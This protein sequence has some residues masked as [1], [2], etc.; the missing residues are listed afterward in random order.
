LSELRDLAGTSK[1][2][3]IDV[4]CPSEEGIF[5]LWVWVQLLR[6]YGSGPIAPAVVDA[7]ALAAELGAQASSSPSEAEQ[8]RFVAF[9]RVVE[10]L[11]RA[12]SHQPLVIAI[13]DLQHADTASLLLLK[14]LAGSISKEPIAL[15]ATYR[16]VIAKTQPVLSRTLGALTREDPT[17]QM[18]LDPLSRADIAALA[19]S[20][21]DR[22]PDDTLVDRLVDK[23]GGNPWLASQM[24]LAL[25]RERGTPSSPHGSTSALL[26][27]NEIK[28]AIG[29]H[30]DVLSDAARE[31]LRSSAVLGIDFKLAHLAATLAVDPMSLLD[32]IEEALGARVL[33]KNSSG[34]YRFVHILVRD[35][36]YRT[37]SLAERTDL[38]E[39]AGAAALDLGMSEV[40]VEHLERALREL[41]LLAVSSRDI[42]S[43][44]LAERARKLLG[45][46]QSR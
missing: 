36:L 4:R 31:V 24:L 15:V 29:L 35:V 13:D 2:R 26:S 45:I 14:F 19:A 18:T 46:L 40:A 11:R 43:E 8:R 16:E 22:K 44:D 33:A 32:R 37:L 3:F 10:L 20:V 38:H 21:L 1:A 25:G 23:S 39:R 17:R 42:D 27:T 9:D 12:A 41:D 28:E 7:A 5:D 34:T 6:E 30:L